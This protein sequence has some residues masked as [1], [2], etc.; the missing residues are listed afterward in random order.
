MYSQSKYDT[1]AK[2][3]TIKKIRKEKKREQKRTSKRPG[4]NNKKA[5]NAII[6][7]TC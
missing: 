6:C 2:T 4:K 5:I 3:G 7:V 1:K